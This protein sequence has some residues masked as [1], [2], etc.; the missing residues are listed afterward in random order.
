MVLFQELKPG[1]TPADKREH[2]LPLGMWPRLEAHAT[3]PS[4]LCAGG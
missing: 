1:A 4:R 2:L 3:A